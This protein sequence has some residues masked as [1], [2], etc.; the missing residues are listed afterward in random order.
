MTLGHSSR[1]TIVFPKDSEETF[2]PSEPGLTF[3]LTDIGAQVAGFSRLTRGY[4]IR[5]TTSRTHIV[6]FTIEGE[7]VA[8]SGA[9]T[10]RLT[11]GTVFVSPT[12]QTQDYRISGDH[13]LIAWVHLHD[14][15]RWSHFKGERP[16][17]LQAINP[18]RLFWLMGQMVAESF[19]SMPN[20][21]RLVGVYAEA[22]AILLERE[23]SLFAQSDNLRVRGRLG[24]LWDRVNKNPGHPW[25]LTELAKLACYSPFHLSRLCREYDKT[26]PMR[27]V[28]RLR[29]RKARELLLNTEM[30]LDMIA[31]QVGYSTPFSF[32]SAFKR[33]C[34][35]YPKTLRKMDRT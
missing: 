7:G 2:L 23:L 26:S 6:L 17:T 12:G 34:G 5:R 25:N 15:T 29:M 21:T 35:V 33:E 10:L 24:D 18:E 16:R 28:T 9:A 13:W 19:S 20:S 14:T 22:L 4:A 30:N 32:S 1:N 8:R 27:M 11:P 3:P 31:E